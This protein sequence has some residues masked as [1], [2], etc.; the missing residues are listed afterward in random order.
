MNIFFWEFRFD[1]VLTALLALG[2]LLAR[3]ERW[4]LSESPSGPAQPPSGFRDLAFAALAVWLIASR[5]TR[6]AV[7]HVAAFT[8]LHRPS[9]SVPALESQ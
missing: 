8:C 9:P 2:L 7:A 5:R 6:D 1:L 3:R 4:A